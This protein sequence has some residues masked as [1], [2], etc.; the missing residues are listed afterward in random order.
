MEPILRSALLAGVPLLKKHYEDIIDAEGITYPKKGSGQAGR[1]LV[2]DLAKAVVDAVLGDLDETTRSEVLSK[3]VKQ[4]EPNEFEGGSDVPLDLLKVISNLDTEN[5]E[6]FKNVTETAIK[7]LEKQAAAA[8]EAEIKKRVQ[9]ASRD[10][11]KELE[12]KLNTPAQPKPEPSAPSDPLGALRVRAAHNKVKAPD[13]LLR[14][15]PPGI[16]QCYVHFK[17]PT[18][19]VHCEF[20]RD[21]AGDIFLHPLVS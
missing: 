2:A 10:Y 21:L 5:K 3:L 4:R 8:K 16:D 13:E 20:K 12:A 19:T 1:V 18:R 15:L 7:M 17:R 11:E 14:L 6:Q 9:K